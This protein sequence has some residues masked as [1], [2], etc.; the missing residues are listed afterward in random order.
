[1]RKPLPLVATLVV[2]AAVAAMIAL[3]VWQLGRRA[4]KAAAIARLAQ[5]IQLPPVA[6]PRFPDEALL[7]RR[8]SL[9]CTRVLST[10]REAGRSAAGAKGWRVIVQCGSGAEG[11]GQAVQLGIAP[12]ADSALAWRGGEVAGYLSYAPDHR[13]LLASV[14]GRAPRPLMLVAATPVAGLAANPGPD[15]SAVPNN[16]LAYAVQWFAFAAIALVIYGLALRR[17]MR[18][19]IPQDSA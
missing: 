10:A 14:F 19:S 6:F 4:D 13:P 15:L 12:S 16:H 9:Y 7:F 18:G 11:P 2:L 17:R 5:N 8:S 3:G 1:M